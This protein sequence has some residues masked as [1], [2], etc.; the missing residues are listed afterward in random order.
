MSMFS[1]PCKM[2]FSVRRSKHDANTRSSCQQICLSSRLL[3]KGYVKS[4]VYADKPQTLDHLEDNI[5]RV[6]ADIRPQM[7]ENVIENWT[8]RLDY[9]RASRGSPMPEI[10]FKIGHVRIWSLENP[11]RGTRITNETHLNRMFLCHNSAFR[12]G[13]PT[14]TG[15]AFI[16]MLYNYG[17]FLI[18]EE[19]EPD[20]FIW[21]QDGAQ[22]HLSVRDW[23]NITV[24]DQWISR[25]GLHDK[26]CFACGLHVAHL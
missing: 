15:S 24:P 21:Q 22:W 20:N 25:K 16:L 18:L 8:S 17:Y 19:S 12:F 13:E 11:P 9:I 10:I 3:E 1:A 26:A 2:G 4:L 6:I 5:R 14:V 7:L 23:L